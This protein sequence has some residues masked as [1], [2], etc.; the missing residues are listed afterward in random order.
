MHALEQAHKQLDF[1]S[2]EY[3]DQDSSGHNAEMRNLDSEIAAMEQRV[4]LFL[5]TTDFLLQLDANCMS[6]IDVGE[7]SPD[8]VQGPWTDVIAALHRACEAVINDA[9]HFVKKGVRVAQIAKLR[10][11]AEDPEAGLEMAKVVALAK[12]LDAGPDNNPRECSLSRA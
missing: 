5:S 11:L 8:H 3:A 9:E 10:R 4:A 12:R 2:S 6:R 1:V 7:I